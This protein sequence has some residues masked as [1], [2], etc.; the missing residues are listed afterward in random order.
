MPRFKSL[1]NAIDDIKTVGP[2]TDCKGNP[3]PNLYSGRWQ[4]YLSLEGP[5]T[6]T[7]DYEPG[8]QARR[9]DPW[10]SDGGPD[11]PVAKLLSLRQGP[12]HSDGEPDNTAAKLL[13]LRQ[14]PRH[15]DGG[16]WLQFR[17]GDTR[18]PAPDI[19]AT[20]LHPLRQDPRP[21]DGGLAPD[22]ATLSCQA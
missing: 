13:S 18:G 6:R 8:L 1:E 3:R 5:I 4:L 7:T 16:F 9:H 10:H 20:E 15:S 12:R 22:P 19:P 14:E 17:L 21:S 11:N 2:G